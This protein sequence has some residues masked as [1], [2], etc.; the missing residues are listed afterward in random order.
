MAEVEQS[1]LVADKTWRN[2]KKF[3]LAAEIFIL[4]AEAGFAFSRRASC[5]YQFER[6]SLYTEGIFEESC[7]ASAVVGIRNCSEL[8]ISSFTLIFSVVDENGE[9]PFVGGN[10]VVSEAS[11]KIPADS[12]FEFSVPLDL[13]GAEDFD[14][15]LRLEEIFLKEI[16]FSEGGTWSDKFGI[17]AVSQTENIGG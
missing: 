11:A 15:E 16:K 10:C 3:I 2:M 6:I 17:Y 7:A 9:N 14:G 4:I 12:Y 8:E 13:S 1:L 5:P